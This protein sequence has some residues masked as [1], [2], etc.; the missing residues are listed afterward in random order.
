MTQQF[1]I[2]QKVTG[3]VGTF[4]VI[5]LREIDGEQYAQVKEY[6][7]ETDCLGKGEFA[8]PVTVL[9]AAA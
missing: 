2:G 3:K 4:V 1:T 6:I 9:K 7:A 5:G 8:L